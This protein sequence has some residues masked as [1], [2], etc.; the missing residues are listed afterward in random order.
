MYDVTLTESYFPAQGDATILEKSVGDILR[1]AAAAVPSQLALKEVTIAGDMGRSWTYA[2]LLATAER[3]ARALLS[4]HAPGDR[5]GV[6]SPNIPEWILIE[7]A[8]GLSGI[9]LVTINPSFQPREV[10]FVLTQS[11]AKALYYVE[12]FRGNPMGDIARDVFSKLDSVEHLIDMNDEAALFAGGDSDIALP[13]V[14]PMSAAQVQYTSGTTGFPKGAVLHHRGLVNN[15]RLHADRLGVAQGD[16]FLTFM[17]L[18]HT[19]G[20]AASVLS[21]VNN[22][23][24]I[25]LVPVFD[26]VH[27]NSII[28]A[29][30][31]THFLAVPTM[32]TGMIEAQDIKKHDLSSMKG[33][34]SGG[35]MVAPELVKKAQQVF[36]VNLQIIYGQTETCPIITMVYAD[37]SLADATTSVGQ[38]MPQTE[39]AILDPATGKVM[40]IGEVGEICSRGYLNMLEYNDN[41]EATAETIDKDGWLH[42]GDLGTMNARGYVAITGRVKEMIIRGG[43][44]LFPAEIENAMLEHPA[45]AE[46]AVVGIPDEKWGELVA[47]FMRAG[48]AEKP[49]PDELKAFCRERLSPQKTP[50]FWVY[51]DE[52]PLTGSGKIRKFL[53]G[54]EFVAG[55]HQAL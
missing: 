33:I 45:L 50:A 41:P 51:V 9:T 35:S 23:A 44:N 28:E 6:W 43:E 25:I 37:D 52:W 4:R 31:V 49:M 10:E 7:M 47:C 21:A 16:V 34:T 46:V 53:L 39:C 11:R 36:G 55:K 8:A 38:P 19:G 5:I 29:E 3:L 2:E 14:D 18:F 15:S 22:K 54:E 1:D 30:K 40:P 42:T 12:D 20:C 48:G 26:P 24:S 27:M 13:P 32:I 17:P